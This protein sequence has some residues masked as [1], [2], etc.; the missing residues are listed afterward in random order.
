MIPG[1]AANTNYLI[2]VDGGQN[3]KATFK[4]ILGGNAL[5]IKLESFTGEVKGKM[6]ERRWM[7]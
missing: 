5:P 1:L 6:N 3:A 2:Y 7:P 4:L